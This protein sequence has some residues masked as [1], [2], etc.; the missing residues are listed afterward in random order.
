[1]KCDMIDA[2]MRNQ[3]AIESA[4]DRGTRKK[5]SSKTNG[6]FLVSDYQVMSDH[7]YSIPVESTTKQEPVPKKDPQFVY[8]H[9]S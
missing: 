9:V 3:K 6:Q 2:I 4:I 1:M 5:S 8:L 7:A